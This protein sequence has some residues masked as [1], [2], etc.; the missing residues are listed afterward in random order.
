MD[1]RLHPIVPPSLPL[2]HAIGFT[3][4]PFASRVPTPDTGDDP[5]YF[6]LY[7]LSECRVFAQLHPLHQSDPIRSVREKAQRDFH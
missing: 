6:G 5:M 3:Y 1:P 4:R 7:H 2:P